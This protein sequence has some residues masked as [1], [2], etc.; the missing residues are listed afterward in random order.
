MLSKTFI[1]YLFQNKSSNFLKRFTY[2]FT[3]LPLRPFQI[4]PEEILWFK[5]DLN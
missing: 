5:N 2:Q 1:N 3:S 4:I